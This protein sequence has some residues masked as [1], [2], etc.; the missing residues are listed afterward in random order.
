MTSVLLYSYVST[1]LFEEVA[2]IG[3]EATQKVALVIIPLFLMFELGISMVKFLM[4]QKGDY[5][6]LNKFF[7]YILIWFFTFQYLP[8]MNLIGVFVDT[9]EYSIYHGVDPNEE[10]INMQE[11]VLTAEGKEEEVVQLA[12]YLNQGNTEKATQYASEKGLTAEQQQIAEKLSHTKE[13]AS[14]SGE[15]GLLDY[16]AKLFSSQFGIIGLI[17]Q[18]LN[19]SIMGALRIIIEILSAILTTFLIAVGPLAIAFNMM[20]FGINDGVLKNWFAT[21]FSIRC[22]MI[23]VTLIDFMQWYLL[24]DTYEGMV[25]SNA[26]RFLND[27]GSIGLNTV[28]SISFIILYIITPYLTNLYTK[29]SGGQ[30]LSLFVGTV[31]MAAKAASKAAAGGGGGGGGGG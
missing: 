18:G 27:V 29:G 7:T 1:D 2:K 17:V 8:V 14:Q 15:E 26:T 30:F 24:K 6:N 5:L 12:I 22:W 31:A 21:W 3:A 19:S 25:N 4:G 11:T 20:P 10:G 23:T 13:I 28:I 9:I 16:L